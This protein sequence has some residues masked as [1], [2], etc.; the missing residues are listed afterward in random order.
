MEAIET[1][2]LIDGC[3]LTTA[4]GD[5]QIGGKESQVTHLGKQRGVLKSTIKEVETGMILEDISGSGHPYVNMC[6][7]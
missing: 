1:R 6:L 3:G 2:E 7:K 5:L 4:N